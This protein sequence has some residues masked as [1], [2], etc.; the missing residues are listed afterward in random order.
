MYYIIDTNIMHN[1]INNVH[2]KDVIDKAAFIAVAEA[3][4]M[5]GNTVTLANRGAIKCAGYI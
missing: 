3:L 5:C 2:R 1:Q 4:N